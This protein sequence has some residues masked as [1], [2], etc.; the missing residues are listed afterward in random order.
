MN[1]ILKNNPMI[2]IMESLQLIGCHNVISRSYTLGENWRNVSA[3]KLTTSQSGTVEFSG[4]SDLKLDLFV[5]C[6][7]EN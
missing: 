3:E 5:I 6:L 1:L 7:S 4:W 2:Y